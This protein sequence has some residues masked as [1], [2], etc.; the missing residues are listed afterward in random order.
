MTDA[1]ETTDKVEE[2]VEPDHQEAPEEDAP[3]EDPNEGLKKALAAERKA[4]REAEKKARDA[5]DALA[6]KD[7]PADEQAVELA[8]R[9]AAEQATAALSGRLIRSE[10]KAALAGKV[11]NPAR[12]L[13]FVNT[14]GIDVDDDGQVDETAVAEAITAFL[15]D[16][17]E[18]KVAQGAGS[19]DQFSK[20]RTPKEP[21]KPNPND[22]IRAVFKKD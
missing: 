13:A 12:V 11:E 6:A 14:D 15:K 4:R 18:F 19:A 2:P 1:V 20:G 7:K 10:V 16:F 3:E 5:A 17:P 22:L 21:D 8:R 9:E